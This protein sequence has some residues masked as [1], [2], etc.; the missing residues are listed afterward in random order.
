MTA[1][2]LAG[3]PM[4]EYDWITPGDYVYTGGLPA[5]CAGHRY[6]VHR[7]IIDVPTFQVK[8]LIETLTGRDAGLWFTC[9]LANFARRYEP[10]KEEPADAQA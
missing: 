9:S 7:R 6:R 2:D 5:G 4:P 8:V 1:T 10:V 3:A